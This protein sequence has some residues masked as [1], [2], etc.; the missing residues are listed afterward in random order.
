V[1]IERK[2]LLGRRV[3]KVTSDFFGYEG[4]KAGGFEFKV[5]LTCGARPSRRRT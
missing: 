5:A 3:V 1:T 2:V 4:E